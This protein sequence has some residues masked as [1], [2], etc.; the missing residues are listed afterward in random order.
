M[1]QERY[2]GEGEGRHGCCDKINPGKEPRGGRTRCTVNCISEP[3]KHRR[4]GGVAMM[5]KSSS[6]SKLPVLALLTS[7]GLSG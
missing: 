4:G 6:Y 1:A 5:L 3:I 2:R 7:T